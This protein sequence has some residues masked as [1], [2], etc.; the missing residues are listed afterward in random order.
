MSISVKVDKRSQRVLLKIGKLDRDLK[1]ALP[2]ALHEIGSIVGRENK[3]IITTGKRSGR[4]YG[5]HQASAEGEA[6]SSRTGALAK[7]YDYRVSSWHSMVVGESVPYAKFLEDG[8]RKMGGR[9]GARQHLIKAINN[10]SG[11]A[12]RIL[13]KYTGEVFNK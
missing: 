6:P 11:D 7:S 5:T 13:Y 4:F 10:K 3:R 9:T 1:K 8:T 12:V 2:S